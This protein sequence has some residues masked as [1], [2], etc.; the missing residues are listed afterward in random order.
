MPLIYHVVGLL[1][2][3]F[4]SGSLSLQGKAIHLGADVLN[5]L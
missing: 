2:V 1:C 5:E 3:W 4:L